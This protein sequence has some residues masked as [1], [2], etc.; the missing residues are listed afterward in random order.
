MD[1]G[2]LGKLPPQ[3]ECPI[4]M[5]VLPSNPILQTYAFCCGKTVCGS[6]DFQHQTKCAEQAVPKTCEFC[7]TALPRSDG[8]LLALACKRVELKDPNALL[9]MAFVHGDGQLGL[10][11]DEAKCIDLLRESADLGFPP[12]QYQLGEYYMNGEMGLEQNEEEAF[13]YWE[14]AAGSG[15]VTSVHNFA[16]FEGKNGNHVAAMRH[17]RLSA[18]GGMRKSMDC[19]I[20]CCF[21]SGLLHHGDLAESLQAMYRARAEL[22]SEDRNTYIE[23]LKRTGEYEEAFGV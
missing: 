1:V 2:P 4:C 10:P 13:K 9:N 6:C 23:H 12:A 17:L 21:E 7:R 19:L 22:R 20:E 14:K 15:D 11:A 3:E 8:E 18:S 16:C 5:R